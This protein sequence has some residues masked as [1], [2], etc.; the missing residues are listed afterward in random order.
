MAT[1]YNYTNTGEATL[2]KDTSNS[3]YNRYY[4]RSTTVNSPT[5]YQPFVFHKGVDNHIQL[6]INDRSRRTADIN[7]VT[8]KGKLIKRSDRS[9]VVTKNAIVDSYDDARVTFKLQPGDVANLDA[10]LYEF[11]IT[12]VNNE[13]EEFLLS[14][15]LNHK[16]QW[17]VELR[18]GPLPKLVDNVTLASFSGGAGATDPQYT[19]ATD[20]SVLKGSSDGLHTVAIYT[21]NF[22]GKIY[23]QG[24]VESEPSSTAGSEDWFLIDTNGLTGYENYAT[25]TSGVRAVNFVHNLYKVRFYYVADASNTGT[26]DKI[27]IRV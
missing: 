7:N 4:K 11:A 27:T 24:S 15:Q 26:V 1:A 14:P 12:S 2:N 6:V 23:V 13:G 22:K 21:T 19:S 16:G 17:T 8:I 5:T 18:E 3:Q 10:T 25:A 9:I 20:G